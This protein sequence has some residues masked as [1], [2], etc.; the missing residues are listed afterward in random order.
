M[1][2]YNFNFPASSI[3][4]TKLVELDMATVAALANHNAFE[5][6]FRFEQFEH[7]DCKSKSIS[8]YAPDIHMYLPS[9]M[10]YPMLFWPNT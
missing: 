7:T 8:S 10:L 3:K 2:V 9:H 4:L 1:R 5:H 6:E